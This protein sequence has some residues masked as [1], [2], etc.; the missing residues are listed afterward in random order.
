MEEF[1]T[2][3]YEQWNKDNEDRDLF[4]NKGVGLNNKLSK[5]LSTDLMNEIYD[6]YCDGCVE[7]EKTAFIA[8]FGYACKCLSNGKVALKSE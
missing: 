8:G 3:I 7:I 4:F 6:I 5:I 2:M 1:A